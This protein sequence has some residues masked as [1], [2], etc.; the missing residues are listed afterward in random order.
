MLRIQD[1]ISADDPLMGSLRPTLQEA[2]ERD[3][4]AERHGPEPLPGR[5]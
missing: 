1:T 4:S 5:S 2:R 3:P